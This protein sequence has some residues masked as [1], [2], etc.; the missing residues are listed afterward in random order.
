MEEKKNCEHCYHP[1]RVTLS[2]SG[3]PYTQIVCCECGRIAGWPLL[4]PKEDPEG[5]GPHHPALDIEE[6]QTIAAA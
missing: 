2:K 1:A 5:H 4:I 6:G 3:S